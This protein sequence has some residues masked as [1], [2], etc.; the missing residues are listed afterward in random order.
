M[1]ES[2]IGGLIYPFFFILIKIMTSYHI[3]NNCNYYMKFKKLKLKLI[4]RLCGKF[5]NHLPIYLD[6]FFDVEAC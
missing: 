2:S 1:I 4:H 3:F 5:S 6:C